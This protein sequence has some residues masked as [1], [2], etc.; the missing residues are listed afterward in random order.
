[1][2]LSGFE[3]LL[4]VI[5][6]LRDPESG[7]PWDLK[8]THKS[9]R[10]YMLEEA[11]EAVNAIDSGEP[12]AIKEELGD[13]LLQVVLH[14]QLASEA[15]FFTADDLAHGIAEKLIRRHP[16]VFGGAS[17]DTAEEVSAN[18]EKIKTLEKKA[19]DKSVMVDIPL[20]IPALSRA[21]K[22]SRRAV[23]EGFEWP[24]AESLWSC[25]MSEF[26]EFRQELAQNAPFENLEEE[27]GDILFAVVNL[28]RT[29]G[30]DPETA[31]NRATNKFIRRFQTMERLSEKP[32]KDQDFETLD[33][34][35]RQSKKI[36][37]SC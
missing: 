18:W 12:E 33:D 29:H 3:K 1:M 35:W 27:L 36:C 9:L 19:S 28:A 17:A 10:P 31:L 22:V 32:L 34:L 25:V 14:A 13:V 23:G 2:T 20:G 15:G 24:D 7:C 30:I 21:L 26:E 4:A 11:Y 16:H 37:S 6:Q 5:R 8:Q